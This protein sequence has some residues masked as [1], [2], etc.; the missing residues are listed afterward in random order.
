MPVEVYTLYLLYR[1]LISL[2]FRTS[3]N[4]AC[5]KCITCGQSTASKRSD[6]K[7]CSDRC[8]MRY[9]RKLKKIRLIQNLYDLCTQIPDHVVKYSEGEMLQMPYEADK[10]KQQL[11]GIE[12]LH[13]LSLAKIESLLHL[14]QKEINMHRLVNQFRGKDQ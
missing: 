14:K 7:Y 10:S 1:Y 11:L 4:N 9:K 3:M 13:S 5:P 8:R 2:L 6:A 12:E